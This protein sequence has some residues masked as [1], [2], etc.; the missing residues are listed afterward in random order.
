MGYKLVSELRL[1][2][3]L[4]TG[5]LVPFRAVILHWKAPKFLHSSGE[6]VWPR[7]KIMMEPNQIKICFVSEKV[8]AGF[9]LIHGDS[10][11]KYIYKF[12][13]GTE[14]DQQAELSQQKP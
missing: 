13:F 10:C 7:P 14:P 9:R 11:G 1:E 2:G 6:Q 12:C 5:A 8:W 3:M 4:F